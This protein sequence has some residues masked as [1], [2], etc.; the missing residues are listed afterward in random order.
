MEQ[1]QQFA[2]DDHVARISEAI[3]S[4]DLS[5]LSSVSPYSLLELIAYLA[6]VVAFAYLL[7]AP[8]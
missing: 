2:I 5:E 4:A 7:K 6:P 8:Q 1:E 3:D